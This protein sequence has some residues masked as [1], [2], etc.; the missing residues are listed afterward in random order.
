MQAPIEYKGK[1]LQGSPKAIGQIEIV[2]AEPDLSYAKIIKK[3]RALKQDDQIVE[4][5]TTAP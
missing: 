1:M 2:S 3:D 4:K 5:M